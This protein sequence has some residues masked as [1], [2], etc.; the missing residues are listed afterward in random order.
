MT[1]TD[2][3]LAAAA[4]WYADWAD[5]IQEYPRGAAINFVLGLVVCAVGVLVF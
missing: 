3:F 2:K 4:D 1:R 5:S